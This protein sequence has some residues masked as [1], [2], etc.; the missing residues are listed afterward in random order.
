MARFTLTSFFFFLLMLRR[1]PRSTLF[2]YTTLFR[3][4]AGAR[5]AHLLQRVSPDERS[6]LVPDDA[7]QPRLVGVALTRE[8]VTVERH[9]RLEAQRVARAEAARDDADR[10]P[11]GQQ[12]VP[13]LLRVHGVKRDLIPA[14]SGV[15]RTGDHGGNT[16]DRRLHRVVVGERGW[17]V[18]RE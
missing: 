11:R 13:H 14:L 15:A 12:R 16:G 1:P 18:G 4:P 2:P 5:I 17:V 9:P 6:L 10:A 3:S 8:L 7:F